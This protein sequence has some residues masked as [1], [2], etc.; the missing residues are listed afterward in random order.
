MGDTCV[1]YGSRL[2]RNRANV[3]YHTLTGG[4][5]V[6]L[7]FVK[8][9]LGQRGLHPDSFPDGRP[10]IN[11]HKSTIALALV[12]CALACTR[13]PTRCGSHAR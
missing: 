13:S 12:S 9:R 3:R 10:M 8:A 4:A 7:A 6:A 2:R 1:W 11:A 5:F